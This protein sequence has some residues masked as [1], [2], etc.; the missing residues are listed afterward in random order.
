MP[1]AVALDLVRVIP[2]A[3]FEVEPSG[4]I[5]APG[6]KRIDPTVTATPPVLAADHEAGIVKVID[7]TET[8]RPV[9]I[10]VVDS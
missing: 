1:G 6:V 8:V 4:R 2:G 3:R 5:A 10:E 9:E 7:V